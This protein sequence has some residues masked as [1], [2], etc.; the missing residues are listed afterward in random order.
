MKNVQTIPTRPVQCGRCAA[1]LRLSGRPANWDRMISLNSA[2]PAI[3]FIAALAMGPVAPEASNTIFLAAG[4]AG[5]LA[6]W[7]GALSELGRPIIWMPLAGLVLIGLAYCL[8][9]GPGGL[10][11]LL[12]FAPVLAIL[13]LVANAG[14]DDAGS[15]TT[16]V[17]LL[18]VCGVFGAAIMAIYE[19]QTTGAV[20]AGEMV[21]NPIHFADVALLVGFLAL[22]GAMLSK[23]WL[24][25]LFILAPL[26]A[27]IPVVLSGTRGAILA[28]VAMM[29][30]LAVTVALLQ[31]VSKRVVALGLVAL[32]VMA[33]IALSMGATQL[34]GI[35]RVMA[36]I[37][38]TLAHG[39][40]TD[41]STDIRLGMY[42][43]GLRA[44]LASPIFGHGPFA[45][46]GIASAMGDGSFS[47]TPHLHSDLVNLAASAGIFGLVA[48]GLIMA[49][50]L[51]EAFRMPRSVERTWAILLSATFL[52][53]YFVMG[54]TNAMFG[55]LTV[56]VTFAT[57]CALVGM[58]STAAQ[59]TTAARQ[60]E[61]GS[62]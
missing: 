57:A 22:A 28:F 40:P 30:V 25:I 1:R 15:T 8:S 32:V 27:V 6:I 48:Y 45:F 43:G 50:P 36:D 38:D 60:T 16:A 13:P 62:A 49:A 7:P 18:S 11:G 54:L 12:F 35:Q 59:S 4:G 52:S 29:L 37:V 53:G 24:R 23:G 61:A 14:R 19:V 17:G 10:E 34:S 33:A 47:D 39:T 20:R 9:A 3:C 21:A 31:L 55:I 5:L 56:T 2:L 42:L 41:D 46:T 44:F 58:L 26:V 51:V